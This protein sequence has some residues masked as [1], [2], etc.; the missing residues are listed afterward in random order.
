MIAMIPKT[1]SLNWYGFSSKAWNKG[2][3]TESPSFHQRNHFSLEL[4]VCEKPKNESPIL[5]IV[6]DSERMPDF[7]DFV[8]LLTS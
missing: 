8:A 7:S 4:D 5:F 3:F 1:C 2:R 6:S